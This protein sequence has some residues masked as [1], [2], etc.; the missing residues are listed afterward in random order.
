MGTVLTVPAVPAGLP[1]LQTVGYRQLHLPRH[2][3]PARGI[4]RTRC[5]HH[6]ARRVGCRPHLQ[7]HDPQQR[8]RDQVVTGA[9]EGLGPFAHFGDEH[10]GVEVVD[11][12][13][14]LPFFQSIVECLKLLLSLLH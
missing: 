3:H 1:C 8:Q 4:L 5:G 12:L 14:Q 6:C 7:A 10:I 2:H 11:N 9:A 13:A